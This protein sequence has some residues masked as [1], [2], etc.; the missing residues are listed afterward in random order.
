MFPE[1][2]ALR[3]G[4]YGA[5]GA[6]LVSRRRWPRLLAAAGGVAYAR[7]PVR[8]AWSRLDDPRDRAIATVV[9]PLLLGWTDAAK[10][11][12]YAAG[13][14]DRARTGPAQ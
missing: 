12:G 9:V 8:R 5:L 14:L 7:E 6:A 13:L 4:V 10:M 3:F 1:R 11:A 2:H